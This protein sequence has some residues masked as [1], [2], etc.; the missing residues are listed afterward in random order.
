MPKLRN[1]T[2]CRRSNMALHLNG[3]KDQKWSKGAH[4]EQILFLGEKGRR[5]GEKS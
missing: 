3:I 4:L 5:K 1:E 2:K